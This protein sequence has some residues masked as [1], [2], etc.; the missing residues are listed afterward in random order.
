MASI[1]GTLRARVADNKLDLPTKRYPSGELLRHSS[2]DSTHQASGLDGSATPHPHSTPASSVPYAYIQEDDIASRPYCSP[3]SPLPF[4]IYNFIASQSEDTG[5]SPSSTRTVADMSRLPVAM[6]VVQGTSASFTPHVSLSSRRDGQ[7]LPKPSQPPPKPA[8]GPKPQNS[9]QGENL[10]RCA[11]LSFAPAG[12]VSNEQQQQHQT[13][14]EPPKPVQFDACDSEWDRAS[15]SE[16]D[17]DTKSRCSMV[18]SC[19]SCYSDYSSPEGSMTY[20]FETATLASQ[21]EEAEGE[22]S[23]IAVDGQPQCGSGD[24]EANG[25]VDDAG[26]SLSACSEGW[27]DLAKPSQLRHR[28]HGQSGNEQDLWSPSRGPKSHSRSSPPSPPPPSPSSPRRR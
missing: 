9:D 17:S 25:D 13:K 2:I 22:G 23:Q 20:F 18:C 24:R 10:L 5:K 15:S 6:T 4:S 16:Y 12:D 14:Q 19:Y 28:L 26:S 3:A 21:D 27:V 1:R 8:P 11:N 7:P